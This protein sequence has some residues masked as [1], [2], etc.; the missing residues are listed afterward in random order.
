[1]DNP[2]S[3]KGD[4]ALRAA[5]E[6]CIRQN[7][8]WKD[9]HVDYAYACVEDQILGG[10]DP[11]AEHWGEHKTF[12]QRIVKRY[13]CKCVIR[14]ATQDMD[15]AR[16]QQRRE[17]TIVII[18]DNGRHSSIAI[19]KLLRVCLCFAEHEIGTVVNLSSRNFMDICTSCDSC[20]A[21]SERVHR[22]STDWAIDFWDKLNE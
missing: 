14:H 19:S 2:R 22:Q 21:K 9:L 7:T 15:H 11:L 20:K 6:C 1:M 10:G 8:D 4:E 18:C 13:G 16:Q 5:A 17:V 12:I 3:F